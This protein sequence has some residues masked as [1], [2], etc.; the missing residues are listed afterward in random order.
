[1]AT[2]TL[3]IG[4]PGSGKSTYAKTKIDR[5]VKLLS[6][7]AI[8]KELF[9]DETNQENNTLVFKTLHERARNFL[10]DGKDVVID[11]TNTNID[12][13]TKTLSSFADLNIK[14]KAIIIETPVELCI[15]RDSR[16]RR[17]VGEDVIK[18]Y[19]ENYTPPTKAEGFD[20]IIMVKNN[21]DGYMKLMRTTLMFVIKDNKILIARKKRGF[22]AGLYNGLG[23]K[24][25]FGETIEDAMIREAYEE[26]NITPKNYKKRAIIDFDEFVKDERTHV[27]MHIYIADDYEGTPTESN[28]MIPVWFDLNKIPFSRMFP[29]DSHW[30][31]EILKGNNVKG[32]F[33][34]DIN[35]NILEKKIEVI[36]DDLI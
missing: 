32:F 10:I 4:L 24:V 29:D 34:Y 35:L 30:L 28:E 18:S 13:R 23:G 17:T 6:S 1:M 3:M 19:H 33:K 2:L 36:N 20:D 8:R 7:D 31:P 9:L 16:R 14:R 27:N 5:K 22:G 12:D 25:E 21:D 11:A 26:A 15:E